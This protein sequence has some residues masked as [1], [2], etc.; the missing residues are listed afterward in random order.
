[1]RM[2]PL[3]LL[4]LLLAPA[5]GIVTHESP[6]PLTPSADTTHPVVQKFFLLATPRSGSSWLSRIIV[7]S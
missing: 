5:R 1:L 7:F 6:K 3:F 2:A 4:A